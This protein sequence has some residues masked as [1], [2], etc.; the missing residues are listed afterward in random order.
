MGRDQAEPAVMIR[1]WSEIAK[2]LGFYAPEVVKVQVSRDVERL[3]ARYAAM[4]DDE[5]LA[6]VAGT[7]QVG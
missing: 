6:I 4:T 7:G 5:L 1:G 2:L 3:E